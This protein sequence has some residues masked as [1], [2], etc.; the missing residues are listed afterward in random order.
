MHM[1]THAHMHKHGLTCTHTDAS[2]QKLTGR[3]GSPGIPFFSWKQACRAGVLQ[4]DW[5]DPAI[6]SRQCFF[7][8]SR[9]W[10]NHL[11]NYKAII[12]QSQV[13]KRKRISS[14]QRE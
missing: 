4:G 12:L 9:A 8:S 6:V 10:A 11:I 2:P 14:K 1:C 7:T 5:K 13:C 3:Q